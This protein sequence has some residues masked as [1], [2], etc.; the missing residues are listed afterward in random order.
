MVAATVTQTPG[1]ATRSPIDQPEA[2]LGHRNAPGSASRASRRPGCAGRRRDQPQRKP[3]ADG[4]GSIGEAGSP[5]GT[6]GPGATRA[7]LLGLAAGWAGFAL[8]PWYALDDGILDPAW[9]IDGWI[10]DR[11]YAPAL[12]QGLWH[13][14][15]WLLPL[16]SLL[17]LPVAALGRERRGA[18]VVLIAAGRGGLA[19]LLLQG[20]AVNH[21][22]V[23]L[24]WA[25]PLLPASARQFGVGW[26]ALVTALSFV[27]LL[28]Q[29]LA[30]RW[31]RAAT[32]S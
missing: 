10:Y 29:G 25:A 6:A 30:R 23:A 27:V 16:G 3:V 18:A 9:L 20:F 13:G 17:A 8:V 7:L 26:G 19:W 11:D 31:P 15:P 4:A 2:R 14:R 12:F 5:G 28:A 22:G 1:S 21:R 32:G 24:A